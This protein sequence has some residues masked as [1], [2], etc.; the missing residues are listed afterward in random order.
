MPIRLGRV[1]DR[2]A[3]LARKQV[4]LRHAVKLGGKVVGCR[5]GFDAANIYLYQVFICLFERV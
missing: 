1:V 4:R 5:M 2:Q 3:G